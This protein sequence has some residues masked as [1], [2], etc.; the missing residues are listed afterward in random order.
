MA[1]AEVRP[2]PSLVWHHIAGM[3]A[4]AVTPVAILLAWQAASSFG[5]IPARTLASPLQVAVTLWALIADGE[6]A[7]NLMVSL[8]R[9]MEGLALGVGIGTVLALISGLS[10]RGEAAVD[11]P[12]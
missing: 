10:R 2:A 3:A 7:D 5:L 11:A 9:A 8:R 12:V 4:R 6:L 1:V